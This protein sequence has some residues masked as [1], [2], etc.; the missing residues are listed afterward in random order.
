MDEFNKW[1]PSIPAIMYHGTRPEREQIFSKKIMKHLHKGRPTKQFPVVCTSYEI[2]LRDQAFL[3]R[4]D[5][6]F[7]IIVQSPTSPSPKSC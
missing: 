3:S 5:W 1:T 4:I 6:E 2:I 7:I